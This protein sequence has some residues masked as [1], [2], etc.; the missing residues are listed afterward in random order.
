[1]LNLELLLFPVTL[2]DVFV[3]VF[4]DGFWFWYLLKSFMG[5]L[6]LLLSLYNSCFWNW[7]LLI[8]V[9][10][11]DEESE[12]GTGTFIFIFMVGEIVEYFIDFWFLFCYSLL[13]QLFF[14]RLLL[15]FVL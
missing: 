10:V 11:V 2:Y 9:D 5:S 3:F 1:M 7:Y 13:I 12:P 14:Y 8:F 15:E 6:L 4:D